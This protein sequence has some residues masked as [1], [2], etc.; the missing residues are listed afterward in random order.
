[1]RHNAGQIIINH[2]IFRAHECLSV[3]ALVRSII[4]VS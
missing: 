4:F 2:S 1:V 3:C